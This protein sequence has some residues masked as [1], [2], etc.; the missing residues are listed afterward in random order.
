VGAV[1]QTQGVLP[2]SHPFGLEFLFFNY[3]IWLL[4]NVFSDRSI[5]I[6]YAL[7]GII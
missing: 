1:A 7:I 3:K 4:N 5:W 2:S 6:P